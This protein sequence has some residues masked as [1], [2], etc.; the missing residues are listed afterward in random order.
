MCQALALWEYAR[1]GD[2]PAPRLSA[3]DLS[4]A[5]VGP[6]LYVLRAETAAFRFAD[7]VIDHCGGALS[8]FC[9]RPAVG[10]AIGALLP[11]AVRQ[12][13]TGTLKA[14]LRLG[15]P[16]AQ[17]GGFLCANGEEILFR[18]AIMPLH[19]DDG[20]AR[21]LGAISFCRASIGTAG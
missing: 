2:E 21:L 18:G 19:C 16:M 20:Q 14:V 13:M 5:S 11:P 4:H 15:K 7:S 8:R 6:H 3:I 10:A 17:S 1:V 9:A 12:E